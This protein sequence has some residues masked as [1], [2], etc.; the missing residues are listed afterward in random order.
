MLSSGS[1][2]TVFPPQDTGSH[3]FMDGGTAWNV[4]LDSAVQQ[5]LELVE[6]QEDII[7]DVT[8]TRYYSAPVETVGKHAWHNYMSAHSIHKYYD[9]YNSLMG[10]IRAYPNINF[11][12]YFQE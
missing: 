11:R 9:N 3:L 7:V 12:Y 6:N 4:N 2:P 5:C 10:Q 1:I 8:I